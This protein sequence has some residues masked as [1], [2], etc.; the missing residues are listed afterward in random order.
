[1]GEG[2]VRGSFLPLLSILREKIEMR[3]PSYLFS[4][5]CGRRLR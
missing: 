3:G 2:W 5:S 4:P 1:V